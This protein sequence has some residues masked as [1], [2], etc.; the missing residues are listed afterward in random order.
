MDDAMFRAFAIAGLRT[1][2]IDEAQIVAAAEYADSKGD[3][4]TAHQL[5]C[6]L[7]RAGE[8]DVGEVE[9]EQARKRLHVIDGGNGA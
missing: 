5:R 9:R 8:R 3:A 4:D 2:D 1:G 7:I 6:L